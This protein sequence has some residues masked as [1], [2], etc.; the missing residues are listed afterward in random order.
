[1]TNH[2]TKDEILAATIRD[3]EYNDVRMLVWAHGELALAHQEWDMGRV[4]RFDAR[5]GP[6]MRAVLSVM[7]EASERCATAAGEIQRTS[8]SIEHRAIERGKAG[9]RVRARLNLQ[10]TH[11][12]EEDY[13]I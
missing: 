8:R 4:K 9:M 1:M 7:G 6:S 3:T 11:T 2:M 13:V 10:E 5:D 12:P